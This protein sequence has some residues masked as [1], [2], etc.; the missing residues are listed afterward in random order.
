M[1]HSLATASKASETMST[2]FFV[3]P[4]RSYPIECCVKRVV[5]ALGAERLVVRRSQSTWE[6]Q[7]DN[8]SGARPVP[9]VRY[10][11][12]SSSAISAEGTRHW[13]AQWA[14]Y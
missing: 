6:Y 14:L 8:S 5:R 11:L 10:V 3:N 9:A 7:P 2:L 13:W 4:I 1:G 12:A